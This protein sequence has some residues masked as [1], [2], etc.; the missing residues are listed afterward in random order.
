[1]KT[2][3]S[4]IR[5]EAVH[6]ASRSYHFTPQ[7]WVEGM[8]VLRDCAPAVDGSQLMLDRICG[9][10]VLMR[11]LGSSQFGLIVWPARREKGEW[12]EQRL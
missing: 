12:L 1:M 10:S 9:T 11:V 8:S 6:A 3:L 5:D 2:G 4:A 7:A